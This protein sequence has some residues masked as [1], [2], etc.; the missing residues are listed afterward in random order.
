MKDMER[1]YNRAD[2]RIYHYRGDSAVCR[3]NGVTLLEAV[4]DLVWHW[5]KAN[6]GSKM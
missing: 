4:A 3:A 1:A 6:P 2:S 5:Q